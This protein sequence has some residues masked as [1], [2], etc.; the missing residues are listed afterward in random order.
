[1]T[2]ATAAGCGKSAPIGV[3]SIHASCDIYDMKY[4]CK[5]LGALQECR[6]LFSLKTNKEQRFGSKT[7]P[8]LGVFSWLDTGASSESLK[9]KQKQEKMLIMLRQAKKGIC[10]S[11]LKIFDLCSLITKNWLGASLAQ[12][13]ERMT[14]CHMTESGWVQLL[15]CL[16]KKTDWFIGRAILAICWCD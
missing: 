15:R 5:L 4:V 10:F 7:K 1:M 14:T 9:Q 16:T 6:P 2:A 11:R 13:V 8:Q 12:C 3:V